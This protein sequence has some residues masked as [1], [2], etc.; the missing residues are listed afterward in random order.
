MKKTSL[1]TGCKCIGLRRKRCALFVGFGVFFVVCLFLLHTFEV[2]MQKYAETSYL[3]NRIFSK[4]RY[5][6]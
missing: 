1:I 5:E 2:F 3:C 6:L 4:Y